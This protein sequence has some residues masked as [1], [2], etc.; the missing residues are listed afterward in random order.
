MNWK[1]SIVRPSFIEMFFNS[2]GP[3]GL[4]IASVFTLLFLCV[5]IICLL[6][7]ARSYFSERKR[8]REWEDFEDYIRSKHK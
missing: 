5:A 2:C 3:G 4:S 6:I 8:Q 1:C 7:A